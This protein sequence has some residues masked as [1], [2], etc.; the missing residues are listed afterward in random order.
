M[1][2]LPAHPRQGHRWNDHRDVI[3][4]NLFR[5]RTG[6]PGLTCPGSTG[7]GRAYTGGIAARAASYLGAAEHHE[8]ILRWIKEGDAT[9]DVLR[10][11][12]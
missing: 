12:I 1:P 5:T 7:T 2:L 4:G 11:S 3:D 9:M 10:P 6:A 8:R